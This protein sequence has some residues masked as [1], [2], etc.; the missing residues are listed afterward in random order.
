MSGAII[1]VAGLLAAA[2]AIGMMFFLAGKSSGSST[3]IEATL[4]SELE[5]K[6]GLKGKLESLYG[7]MVD[8]A[9]CRARIAEVQ[10]V[11]D[12]L[13]AERGRIT[14]TQAEL[15][16][17]E[18]RLRELEEIERELEASGLETKEELNILEK[19]QKELASKN[20]QLK[21]Q[22]ETSAA[23]WEQLIK[24]MESNTQVLEKIQSIKNELV[25]TED[26]VATLMLQIDQ[27][28][29]QYFILKRRYDALDIEYAQLYEKFSEA[30]AMVSSAKKE[31]S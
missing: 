26:K 27:G 28:N 30:E 3:E 17:V 21:S 2:T 23:Q 1:I 4:N 7:Q 22:I 16:T 13:K 25:S 10:T 11:Q 20:S 8:V 12:S 24:E 19:K 29:D 9:T 31:E 5:S 15:E 14:I 6:R 18:T